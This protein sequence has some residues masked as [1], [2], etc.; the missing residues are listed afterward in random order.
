[1]R[2]GGW[3]LRQ[4]TSRKAAAREVGIGNSSSEFLPDPFSH[5]ASFGPGSRQHFA[6]RRQLTGD[7]PAITRFCH[8]DCSVAIHSYGVGIVE[9]IWQDPC[10]KQTALAIKAEHRI[11]YSR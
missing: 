11:I 7:R 8:I 2:R 10:I 9:Q 3:S 6:L 5:P 4:A 1:M